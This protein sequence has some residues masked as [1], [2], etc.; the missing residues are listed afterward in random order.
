MRPS[1]DRWIHTGHISF[2]GDRLVCSLYFSILFLY[3]VY[4]T[5]I[6]NIQIFL[7]MKK[8]SD[9]A[10]YNKYMAILENLENSWDNNF[11]FEHT[12]LAV[13][14]F[15]DTCCNGCLCQTPKD[16]KIESSCVCG[17]ETCNC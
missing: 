7:K 1:R 12:S 16:H 11:Q 4:R 2:I 3:Y 14:V 10:G 17:N 8:Y 5:Q 9:L 6:Q 15:T 13:K